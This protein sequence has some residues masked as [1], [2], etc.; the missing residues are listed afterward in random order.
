[1]GG[2]AGELT[3]RKCKI[4]WVKT[5]MP[6]LYCGLGILDLEIGKVRESSASEMAMKSARKIL[7]GYGNPVR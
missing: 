3:G 2:A 6:M 5:G 7:G 4:N 1:M